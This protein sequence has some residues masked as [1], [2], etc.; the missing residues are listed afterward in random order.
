M[1]DIEDGSK[2]LR[3]PEEDTDRKFSSDVV[4]END[5][6]GLHSDPHDVSLAGSL[7][8]GMAPS[9][10]A[11]LDMAISK[12]KP[13]TLEDLEPGRLI[14]D[15]EIIA[16]L[17]RG[18]FGAVYLARQVS[19]DRQVALKVTLLQVT[20]GRRMGRLEHEHIVQVFSET[21]LGGGMRLLCMQYV[22]GASLQEVLTALEDVPPARRN[23]QLL[24]ETID[25]LTVRPAAFDAAAARSREILAGFDWVETVCW[26]GAR[27]GEALDFAHSRGVFHRDIK[28]GNIMLS[29][30][31]RPLLVD[32]NLALQQLEGGKSDGHMG[33][34]LAYM[35]PEHLAAFLPGAAG[36]PEG[37]AQA[38]DIYSLGVVLYQ[39]A[40]GKLP[41]LLTPDGRSRREVMRALVDQRRQLPP[42]LPP[43]LPLPLDQV[44]AR[45]MHPDP[46]QR[47]ASGC[48]L[49]AAL[50]GCR[51]SLSAEREMPDVGRMRGVVEAHPFVWLIILALAPQIVATFLNIAYNQVRIISH[52]T[53]AQQAVFGTIIL[54]YNSYGYTTGMA[55]SLLAVLPVYWAWRLVAERLPSDRARIDSARRIA[56]AWPFVAALTSSMGWLPG[57]VVFG[58]F[59]R[60][61]GGT[62]PADHWTHL[63]ISFAISGLIAL[64][65]SMLSVQWLALC[66]IYPRLWADRR[67]FRATAA[68]ELRAVPR[69]LR[70]LQ[71]LAGV[72]PLA[73]AVLILMGT[74]SAGSSAG[75]SLA[76][77]LLVASLIIL[78]AA[79]FCLAMFATGLLSRA[80][81]ALTGSE[82]IP[83]KKPPRP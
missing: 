80:V 53:E 4:L 32:F 14:D 51:H 41:F 64:T 13:L 37:V 36:P 47:F 3:L 73:G 50:E 28:P 17:G 49:S 78:G 40:C 34:T 83:A 66:V 75:E 61:V 10:P 45:A 59:L 29:Q 24:L 23:G 18:A 20:E 9:C 77:R 74:G 67:N 54:G 22:P 6:A 25:R 65:Y 48:E 68:A 44:V 8:T 71:V 63:I 26:L 72:I 58:Y 79:G 43:D 55:I 56:V 15:F 21:S 7:G 30:Y 27:L 46:R 35:A 70:L 39:S 69:R 82:G 81:A 19:L 62:L 1:A 16:S 5:A 33:G 76:F 2:T 38:A 52:L 60:R 11:P 12:G 31:G 42:P 57:G